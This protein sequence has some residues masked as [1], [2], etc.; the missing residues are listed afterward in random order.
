ML[1]KKNYKKRSQDL[2]QI[3]C[4]AGQFYWANK[5]TW[6]KEEVIF[7]KKSDIVTVPKWRYQDI[8]TLEDWKR[9]EIIAKTIY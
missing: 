7:S 4:D 3:M 2:M 6:I 8:D 1:F 5:K 9:A